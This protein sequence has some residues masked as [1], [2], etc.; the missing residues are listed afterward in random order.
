MP[1]LEIER[2]FIIKLPINELI[3]AMPEYS[4]SE[5]EQIYIKPQGV[6]TSRRIRRRKYKDGSLSFTETSKRRI[7]SISAAEAEREIC[8]EEY[9]SL[10]REIED[11]TVPLYKTRKT[12]LYRSHTFELDVYPAWQTTC[13]MEVE[14]R[15]PD[16]QVDFPPELHIIREVSGMREY[17]NHSMARKFP[18]EII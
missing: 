16:E 4:E 2:K 8:E 12:F 14:L 11:T 5:I 17:S 6:F 15:S 13:I 1:N 7:S 9:L 18:P 3:E 10:S